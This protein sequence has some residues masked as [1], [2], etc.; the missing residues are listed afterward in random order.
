MEM[1][2]EHRRWALSAAA[3]LVVAAVLVAGWWLAQPRSGAGGVGS[4]VGSGVDGGVAGDPGSVDPGAAGPASGDPEDRGAVPGRRQQAVGREPA[5][6]KG[7][8]RVDSY[9]ERGERLLLGYT[10]GVP[11]CY[12]EVTVAQVREGRRAVTVALRA[13]PPAHPAEQ[14]IDLAVKGTVAVDLSAPLGRRWVLDGGFEPAVLV[15]QAPR[16]HLELDV[17]PGTEQ[18]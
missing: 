2:S 10:T 9:V 5:L 18:G 1:S 13:V 11:E 14:C 7:A 3:A 6:V 16:P 8:V 15:R 4:G 12:G 17:A